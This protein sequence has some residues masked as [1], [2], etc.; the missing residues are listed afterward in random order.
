[1]NLHRPVAFSVDLKN[2]IINSGKLEIRN[3]NLKY[4]HVKK[5]TRQTTTAHGRE[6]SRIRSTKRVIY[7]VLES[8]HVGFCISCI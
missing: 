8:N 4:K 6:C 7:R 3:P 5:S 2:E 1:M